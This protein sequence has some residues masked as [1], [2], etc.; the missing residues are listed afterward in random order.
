MRK[1]TREIAASEISRKRSKTKFKWASG[2]LKVVAVGLVLNRGTV[3]KALKT[4][5]ETCIRKGLYFNLLAL[6]FTLRAF[7]RARLIQIYAK[8]RLGKMVIK[9]HSASFSAVIPVL[10]PKFLLFTC[11]VVRKTN[12]QYIKIFLDQYLLFKTVKNSTKIKKQIK[13]CHKNR[14]IKMFF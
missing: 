14:Y 6:K 4:R 8:R 12:Y 1:P 9:K 13:K 5:K 2:A 3:K 10:I 11:V 7:W